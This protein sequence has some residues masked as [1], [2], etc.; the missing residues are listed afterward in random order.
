[1]RLGSLRKIELV[2]NLHCVVERSGRLL[3]G[4]CGE[5][6]RGDRS[7]R[8]VFVKNSMLPIASVVAA[9]NGRSGHIEATLS[10]RNVAGCDLN[11]L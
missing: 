7:T 10:C 3:E 9:R 11:M 8:E 2:W 4:R 1:M 5:S 6:E